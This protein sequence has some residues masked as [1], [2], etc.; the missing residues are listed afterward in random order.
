MACFGAVALV[1]AGSTLYLIRTYFKVS[2]RV[3]GSS[4][5]SVKKKDSAGGSSYGS[6]SRG[7]NSLSKDY[8]NL[9]SLPED[10]DR[11]GLMTSVHPMRVESSDSDGFSK[12][13]QLGDALP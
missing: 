8:Q 1:G 4:R 7:A 12:S 6:R 9:D 5:A 13:S 10:P 2:A 3:N 11:E